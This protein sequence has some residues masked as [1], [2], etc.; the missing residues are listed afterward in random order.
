[1]LEETIEQLEPGDMRAEALIRL[2]VVRLYGDG[3][4]E[5]ARLLQR[6]LSEADADSPLRVQILITLAYAL[7]HA[8]QPGAAC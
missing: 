5:G 7:L 1:M 4:F 8:N 3:F 2:A 6:A